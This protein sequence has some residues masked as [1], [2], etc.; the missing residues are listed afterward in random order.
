M[1]AARHVD[2]KLGHSLRLASGPCGK[3][4]GT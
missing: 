3:G 1:S 4:F 2:R